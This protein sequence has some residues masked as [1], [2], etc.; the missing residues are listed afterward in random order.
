[1]L[2]QE[3][4]QQIYRWWHIFKNDHELVEIR[5]VGNKG[6]FSG[7]YKNIENLIRD[8]NLHDDCNVYFTVN[9]INDACHGRPQCEQ[10]IHSP[11][12]TTNDEEII[13]RSFIYIDFDSAKGWTDGKKNGISNVNS[14]DEEKELA[15]QK[16]LEVYRYLKGEGFNEPIIN[17]SANGFHAYY[18]CLLSATEE[19]DKL[20]ERFMKSLSMMFSDENVV[21]DTTAT[22]RA[23][24]SKLPGTFS[25][26]GSALSVDRPQ[27]MCKILKVPSELK[28]IPKEYF[29]KIADL[30]PE[31]EIKPTRENNYSTSKFDLYDF[32]QRNNISY[33]KTVKTPIGTRYLLD[34][35]PFDSSHVHGDAMV[36]QHNGGGLQFSCFH[37]SC[38]QYHWREFRLHFEPDAYEKKDY[39]E[40]REKRRYYEKYRLP[41]EPTEIKSENEHDGK[42]WFT[43]RDI[44]TIR[45]ADKFYVHTGIYALDKAIG[46]LCEGETTILSGINAS[47]K[48]AILNQLLLTAV[49]QGVPSALWSGE[50]PAEKIKAWLCQTAA[51][52]QNVTKIPNRDNSYEAN[53]DVIP[54]IE[55]WLDDKLVIYNNKYGNNFEQ[56]ISDIKDAIT[57]YKLRF[58]VLDN[59]MA[60]SLEDLVGT[61][62]EQQKKL[63]LRLDGLAK[64]FKIHVLIIAHPRKEAN[65][66]LLR[67]ESISGTSDLTNITCN[68]FLI[69]RVGDDFERRATEF[70]GKER[71]SRLILEGY[72]NI[73]EV[74]KNR[75]DGVADFVVGLFYEPETKRFKNS[76]AENIHYDWEEHYEEY[77]VPEESFPTTIQPN[78]AFDTP[79]EPLYPEKEDDAYWGQFNHDN[80]PPF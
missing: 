14:T 24:I 74:A 39:Q 23:R 42:K 69:H 77:T 55:G 52:K 79:I 60:L 54:K 27:R 76:K 12:N 61:Q 68:L 25:R 66:Q 65:F 51:G 8:V 40:Y 67:K 22:N 59:L 63:M 71:T 9:D 10:M 6:T 34:Q 73:I 1:M 50:L 3:Q 80:E 48:T 26:K 18:P 15:H 32:L 19:N 29:Q 57:K 33:Y 17:D 46:G 30:Y 36:F 38:S 43:L 20:V 64:D 13:G 78:Q 37:N 35:C 2:T 53:D 45:N 75:D 5:C 49:Q 28:P 4:K 62:N 56:I 31:E 72:N 44:K 47:G 21:V 7:Y 70:W 41:S 11:K 16:A 58:V